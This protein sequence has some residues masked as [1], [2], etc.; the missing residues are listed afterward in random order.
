MDKIK[1]TS[2]GGL[3]QTGA[4]NCMLYETSDSAIIVDCGVAFADNKL[5]GANVIIPDF[6]FLNPVI[7]KLKAVFLTHGHED[8][9]GALP[10]LLKKIPLP[11][12]ATAFT[13]GIVHDKLEEFKLKDIKVR[14]LCYDTVTRIDDV[15]I[16]PIFVNHSIM[17]A[18]ALIIS[19]AD[20]SVLHCSDF[21]ID[22][23]PPE[24]RAID[25][26]RFKRLG[27][28]GLDLLMLDSTNV[29]NKGHTNSELEVRAN[30]LDLFTKT[31]GRIIACLFSSNT[32]RLQSLFECARITGRKVAM[33][34]RSLRDYFRIASSL[35]RIDVSGVDIYDVEEMDDFPD[36][37]ILV[38]TTGSQAEPRSV[39]SR[40]S[41]NMFRP[42]RIKEGD[43]VVMSSRMIPGNEGRIW[44][45][46]NNLSLLGARVIHQPLA[47]FIHASG[48]AKEDELREIIRIVRPR[49]FIPIHGEHRSLKRHAEVASEEGVKKK[50]CFV[51]LDG[52]S[53]TLSKKGLFLTEQKE[54]GRKFISENPQY[55]ITP[56]AL[57]KRS[58]MAW[59]GL[60][61]V[62]LIYHNAT[63]RVADSVRVSSEGIFGGDVEI[64]AL[65]ALSGMLRA[66]IKKQSNAERDKLEKF[67]TIE[68]RHF[69]KTHYQI[70]PEV[71]V[72]V[73]EVA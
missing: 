1:I 40:M 23:S 55:T 56:A 3:G 10:Y 68:V 5:P 9:V 34:G 35:G 33:T 30:L 29:M 12:Y 25:L 41:R 20:V 48:H 38:I 21:K 46:L 49:Y 54:V 36:G 27:K 44:E 66:L 13:R 32:F 37:E 2:L 31:D 11:V 39:L 17:D 6:D 62:S 70:R 24:N 59:N 19:A 47:D 72:L 50:N 63:S 45:L 28:E 8:H 4:L 14:D 26:A 52:E 73:H 60:V 22:L 71:V 7:E 53:L 15:S 65:D 16:E 64:E 43:T 57:R 67:V 42:F 18:A 61:T 58:K 69:Y 51:V